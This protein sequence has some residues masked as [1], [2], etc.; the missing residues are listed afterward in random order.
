MPAPAQL[1]N[2]AKR[3]MRGSN[4]NVILIALVYIAVTDLL[5]I[6]FYMVMFPGMSLIDISKL[7][8]G[9]DFAEVASS[10]NPAAS[11]LLRTAISI[12]SMMLGVGMTSVC[13]N[14]SRAMPAGFATLF[15]PF[16]LFFKFLLLNILMN[17]Y[18]FLWSLLLFIPGIIASYRYSMAVY[19]LLDNPEYSVSECIRLSKEMMNGNKLELFVLDLSF[20]GWMILTIIPFVSLYVLPYRMTTRANF[21]NALCGYVPEVEYTVYDENGQT[22]GGDRDSGKDPWD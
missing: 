1:K 16:G 14:V 15:D 18:I 9:G 17:I 19:I 20:I 6:L 3:S 11:Q 22:G 2:S 8:M 10:A 4:P 5:E 21:Y 7:L 13:L 12:M